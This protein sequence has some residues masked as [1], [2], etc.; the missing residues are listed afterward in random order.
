MNEH[1]PSVLEVVSS[2]TRQGGRVP[3]GRRWAVW[4]KRL[5]CPVC[6]REF[7]RLANPLRHRKVRCVGKDSLRLLPKGS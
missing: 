5:R 1:E 7:T 4:Y 6:G 2:F 3:G